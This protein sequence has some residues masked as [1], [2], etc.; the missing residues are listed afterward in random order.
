MF[1]NTVLKPSVDT[2]KWLKA[3]AVRAVKTFAQTFVSL[4]AVGASVSEV[5]W[6]YVLSVSAVALILSVG[7]SVAGLPEVA[8]TDTALT[9]KK[10]DN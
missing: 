1:K 9:E 4:I 6:K 3:T 10:E 5:D 7:T 8:D 2:Q